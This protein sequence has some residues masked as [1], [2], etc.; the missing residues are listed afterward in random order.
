MMKQEFEKLAMRGGVEISHMLYE[1]IERH[2]MNDDNRYRS[3]FGLVG[4][5]KQDFVK[6]VFGGKINTPKTIA[7]KFADEEVRV[8]RFLLQN[9]DNAELDHLERLIRTQ[10]DRES[11]YDFIRT[12]QAMQR[13]KATAANRT[14]Y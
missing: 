14:V 5:T 1:D 9:A 7:K 13:A 10:I 8:H 3:Y 6:R 2:Y 11:T 12:F 4:E